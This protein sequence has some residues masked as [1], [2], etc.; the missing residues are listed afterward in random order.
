MGKSIANHA[1]EAKTP[2]NTLAAPAL[3]AQAAQRAIGPTPIA[4]PALA[5]EMELWACIPQAQPQLREL[6]GLMRTAMGANTALVLSVQDIAVTVH[7][8]LGAEI[9]PVAL[10]NIGLPL[11]NT[12]VEPDGL[13]Q[14][15]APELLKMLAASNNSA[16]ACAY[17]GRMRV[18]AHYLWCIFTKTED[19]KITS[20]RRALAALCLR[21]MQ[22][23]VTVHLQAQQQALRIRQMQLGLNAAQAGVWQL[24]VASGN[25]SGDETVAQLLGFEAHPLQCDFSIILARVSEAT[26]E[27]LVYAISHATNMAGTNR[28]VFET[29][30]TGRWLSA[31]FIR[32]P[33]TPEPYFFGVM[34]DYSSQRELE[35]ENQ[36]HQQQLE[37]LV[38]DLR[39]SNRVDTLTGLVNR[40]G[41][42]EQLQ[43]RTSNA[44]RKQEWIS[45]LIIDVDHFKAFNDNY[46]HAEGDRALKQVAAEIA[47]SVRGNDIAA[48]FGG[49]EFCVLCDADPELAQRIAERT[50]LAVEQ[51]SWSARKVTVSIGVDSACGADIDA[52][53]LFKRADKALYQ[54]KA[55]GRN[56]I[57]T[58]PTPSP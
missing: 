24:H 13:S 3:S 44:I 16:V 38:R 29:T 55:A 22:A 34:R 45:L 17:V 37:V 46:G 36:Q 2:D 43:V 41:L 54:A 7:L 52:S 15:H 31:A 1:N 23:S 42:N 9:S 18:G 40:T 26:R 25:F 30:N 8:Q 14:V 6:L 49:E 10:A 35:L 32:D 12:L 27:A 11:E 47:R 33:E 48:R 57:M 28:A 50:R 53:R 20:E 5:Q 51:S 58:A 4:Q 56:R 21:Q 39:K 19:A